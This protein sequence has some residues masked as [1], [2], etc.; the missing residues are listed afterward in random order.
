MKELIVR[1]T[2]EGSLKRKW[3]ML[4]PRNKQECCIRNERRQTPVTLGRE[5]VTHGRTISHPPRAYVCQ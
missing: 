1:K 4:N 3:S 5:R 2:G